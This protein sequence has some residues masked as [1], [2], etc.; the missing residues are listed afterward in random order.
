[1]E[2]IKKCI[3]CKKIM[4]YGPQKQVISKSITKE[5][6]HIRKSVTF[7]QYGWSCPMGD[8]DC[9]IVFGEEDA[10]KNKLNSE[11]AHRELKK[12]LAQ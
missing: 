4:T 12:L 2:E 1:M 9:D 10:H 11:E 8:D 5:G 6:K 3:Y 7:L